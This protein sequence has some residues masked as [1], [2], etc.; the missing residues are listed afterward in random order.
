ML[1]VAGVT[2]IETSVAALTVNVVVAET[3]PD[4]AVIV[5]EP[6]A[7]DAASPLEPAAL[8]TV[9]TVVFEELQTTTEVRFCVE[10][11]E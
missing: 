8:L 4:A 6:A 2:A 10:L 9:A 11:S 7:T 1:A 5:S 3:L